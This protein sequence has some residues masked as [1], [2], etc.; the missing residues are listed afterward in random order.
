MNCA[1]STSDSADKRELWPSKL[2]VRQQTAEI[3]TMSH[4]NNP[5]PTPKKKLD[6]R[7]RSSDQALD[8]S[9]KRFDIFLIDTGWNTAVGKLVHSHLTTMF[10]FQKDDAFYVL[11]PE[12]SV[13]ILRRAPHLIGHDP[14]ILVYDLAPPPN[15]KCRGYRGFRLNLG[16]VKQPQQALARLQEFLRFI[17]VNRTAVPLDR[18]IRRELYREGLDGMVKILREASTELI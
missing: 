6:L 3:L 13:E 9:M 17:A 10:G 15:R 7:F 1:E 11:S 18:A 8:R 4:D 5:S 16:L 14:I 12:Q 2:T